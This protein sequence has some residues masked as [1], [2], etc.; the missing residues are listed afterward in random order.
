MDSIKMIIHQAFIVER[1]EKNR[2]FENG[3]VSLAVNSSV[4]VY[5]SNVLSKYFFFRI[6]I[7]ATL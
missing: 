1:G 5:A 4:H 6:L 7:Y 3:P 2:T